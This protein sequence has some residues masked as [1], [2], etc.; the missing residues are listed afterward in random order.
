MKLSK[1]SVST[2]LFSTKEGKRN[3]NDPKPPM[4][5]DAPNLRRSG[6]CILREGW[7]ADWNAGA[8]PLLAGDKS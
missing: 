1:N 3:G 5:P 2:V 6:F 7:G 8:N 4:N